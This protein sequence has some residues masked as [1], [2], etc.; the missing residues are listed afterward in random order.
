MGEENP[1]NGVRPTY[2]SLLEAMVRAMVQHPESV[3]VVCTVDARGVLLTLHVDPDDRR[4]VIGRQGSMAQSIRTVIKAIGARFDANVSMVIHESEQ[5][6]EAHH[7]SK[8]RPTASE[9]SDRAD[10]DP[11]DLSDLN[12]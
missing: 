2:H 7:A 11:G 3:E 8:P 9:V 4:Y 10:R 1:Q 5:E 6:R 12:I